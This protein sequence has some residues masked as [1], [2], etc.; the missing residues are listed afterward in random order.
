MQL[1]KSPVIL[2]LDLCLKACLF[3]QLPEL[4]CPGEGWL[5]KGSGLKLEV[6]KGCTEL[7]L[8]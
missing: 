2:S 4:V 6:G 5:G 7:G 3:S 8:S 1:R